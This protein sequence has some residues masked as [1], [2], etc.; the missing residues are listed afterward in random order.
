LLR[1]ASGS[2]LHFSA[3]FQQTV[4]TAGKNRAICIP[5]NGYVHWS[6]GLLRDQGIV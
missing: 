2:Q 3:L 6:A 4:F 5:Y 1:V